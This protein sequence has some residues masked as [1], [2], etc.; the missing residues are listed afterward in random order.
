MHRTFNPEPKKD[1]RFLVW[2]FTRKPR[3]WATIAGI[4]FLLFAWG[5]CFQMIAPGYT[6]IVVNLFGDYKG[7]LPVAKGTGM[8][9]IAPWKKIYKFPVFEQNRIWS[10][11]WSF[12][13]QSAEGLLINA[14][15]GISYHLDEGKVHILFAKYR[16]G[17]DEITDMFIRM[18]IR[19]AINKSACHMKVEE[20]YGPAKETFISC[21]QKEVKDELA[22]VGIVIDRVYLIGTL[23][24][25]EQ[26]VAALNSKIEATQR[27][28]QRENELREAQAQAQKEIAH[29]QGEAQKKKLSSEAEAAATM[30][31]AQAE[32]EANRLLTLSLS[33]EIIKYQAIKQWDGKLPTTLT[34]EMT[35][36]LKEISK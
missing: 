9:W 11:E 24:F 34:G 29:A 17:L 1:N 32:A 23:H 5:R 13:F 8:H 21:I 36:I 4:I 27:A 2:I 25:P 26:V 14:D 10:K 15:L 7:A 19:D 18:H 20:L 35:G 16:R 33:K 31:K 30:I 12:N 22:H 28:Q 3:F 6:G